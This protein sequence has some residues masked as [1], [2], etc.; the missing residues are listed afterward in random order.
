MSAGPKAFL[1]REIVIN[2]REQAFTLKFRV[3]SIKF[4]SARL[5][6]PNFPRARDVQQDRKLESEFNRDITPVDEVVR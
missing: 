4:T 3:L 5:S 6:G 1:T 2:C